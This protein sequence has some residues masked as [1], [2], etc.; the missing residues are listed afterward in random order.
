M[1]KNDTKKINIE[2]KN[3]NVTCNPMLIDRFFYNKSFIKS[4]GRLRATFSIENYGMVICPIRNNATLLPSK[5]VVRT[6]NLKEFEF[7]RYRQ[8]IL[9]EG[10]YQFFKFC[11]QKNILLKDE[12]NNIINVFIYIQALRLIKKFKK[13]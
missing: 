4:E 9:L 11:K 8:I 12:N 2:L 7:Y 3:K 10:V 13:M 6:K 5:T 1:F